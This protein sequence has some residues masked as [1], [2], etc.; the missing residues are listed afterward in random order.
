MISDTQKSQKKLLIEQL[1][2]Q[3]IL[4]IMSMSNPDM[5]ARNTFSKLID[6]TL[7]EVEALDI[8][9]FY[10]KC[11]VE[12]LHEIKF[13]IE[14]DLENFVKTSPGIRL[15][16]IA[17][18]ENLMTLICTVDESSSPDYIQQIYFEIMVGLK[19]LC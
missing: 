6:M 8:R 1:R 9:K 3:K 17:E 15:D 11:A 5:V 14:K 10:N 12:T 19:K 2:L 13:K 7:N 18:L 16:V 4:N